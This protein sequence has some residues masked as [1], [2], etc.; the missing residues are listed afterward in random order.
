MK[1]V[2][3]LW[4]AAMELPKIGDNITTEKARSLCLHFDLDELVERI[5]RDPGRYKHWRFDGCSCLPDKLLGLF[6]GCRW[7]D[8]TYRCCL[9][10]DLR[11]GY[12]ESG[13]NAERKAA[14]EQFFHDLIKKA[15]MRRWLAA[16][17]MAGV[18]LGGAEQFGL[19]FS[20]AFADKM[21]APFYQRRLRRGG[22]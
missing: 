9:P 16:A 20:W 19:S 4:K 15:G 17:F 8:I 14:D 5:D 18:R 11:Y 22:R 13:N 10:H 21:A 7:Q 12:G 2:D 1:R 6:A 3:A